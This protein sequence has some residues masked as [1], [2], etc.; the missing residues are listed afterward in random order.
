MMKRKAIA[1][2]L[3]SAI[4]IAPAFAA[5]QGAYIGANVGQSSTDTLSMSTKTAT[6]YSLLAGYQFMRNLAAE[7]QWN[8]FGSPTLADGTSPKI[9]GYSAKLVGILPFNDQWSGFIKLGYAHVKMGGN[10]QTSKS[11]V[12]YGIGVEYDWVKNWG[13]NLNYDAYSVTG[14]AP[15]SQKATTGVPSI[16]LVYKF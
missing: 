12:T 15:A 11:D 2:L 5:E 6:A 7:V 3:L 14:P 4:S 1:A 8:D 16:G 10:V 13:V 9:D